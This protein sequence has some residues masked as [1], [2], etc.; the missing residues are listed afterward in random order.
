ML[1]LNTDDGVVS[2]LALVAGR[3]APRISN[4]TRVPNID[5]DHAAIL[6]V[7][8][9]LIQ[10]HLWLRPGARQFSETS[11]RLRSVL[12]RPTSVA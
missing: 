5:M 7:S 6:A 2:V 9:R 3:D 12:I 10:A 11:Q 4:K 1:M 8:S